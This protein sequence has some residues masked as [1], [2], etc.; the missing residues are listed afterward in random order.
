MI[1][2]GTFYKVQVRLS[3]DDPWITTESTTSFHEA[4]R[5]AHF[6]ELGKPKKAE[7]RVVPC[8]E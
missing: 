2:S 1:G 5:S 6:W 8:F 4:S 3:P 7:V